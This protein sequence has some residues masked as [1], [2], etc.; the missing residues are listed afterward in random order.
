ML[1]LRM[2][3]QNKSKLLN[4]KANMHNE[5]VTLSANAIPVIVA[6]KCADFGNLCPTSNLVMTSLCVPPLVTDFSPDI[7]KLSI[8]S[9]CEEVV[10]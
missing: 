10:I 7:F 8:A 4:I 2:F 9:V 5:V 1:V 6:A 3:C